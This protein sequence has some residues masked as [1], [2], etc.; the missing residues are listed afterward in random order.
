MGPINTCAGMV[1]LS[2][3]WL[4][5]ESQVVQSFSNSFFGTVFLVTFAMGFCGSQKK[6]KL[7]V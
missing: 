2:S 1:Y 5:D 7:S 3:H 6:I 4:F